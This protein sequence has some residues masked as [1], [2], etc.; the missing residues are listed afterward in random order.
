MT[1]KD[2]CQKDNKGN[3]TNTGFGGFSCSCNTTTFWDFDTLT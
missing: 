3:C 1:G 2:Y